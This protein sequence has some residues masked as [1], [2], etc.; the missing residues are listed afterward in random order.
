M[1]YSLVTMKPNVM[2]RNFFSQILGMNL[3]IWVSMKARRTIMKRGSFDNYIMGTKPKDLDSKFGIFIKSMMKSKL[4]DP[5]FK[6]PPIAGHSTQDRTRKT[7]YWE[8]RNIPSV[9]MPNTVKSA[10]QDN[11]EYY[12]KTPQEMSRYEIAELEQELREAGEDGGDSDDDEIEADT[13][14]ETERLRK[15]PEHQKWMAKMRKLCKLRHGVIKRYFEKYKYRKAARNE[16]IAAAEASEEAIK[17][18]M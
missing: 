14:E 6:L 10:L 12:V 8:Y 13:P 16:I 9:Y 18:M 4:K 7:K 1:K 11:T 15:C 17:E 3:R 2:R 5:K